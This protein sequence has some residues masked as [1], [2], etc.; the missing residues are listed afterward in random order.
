[1]ST[2]DPVRCVGL[3]FSSS[4]KSQASASKSGGR[5][6][7]MMREVLKRGELMG[8]WLMSK[9]TRSPPS[10]FI[11]V[12]S[13]RSG[14]KHCKAVAD[15]CRRGN[16]AHQDSWESFPATLS[17]RSFDKDGWVNWIGD[18]TGR[19]EDWSATW[20]SVFK[21]RKTRHAMDA[22]NVVDASATTKP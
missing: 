4:V 2:Y 11:R 5:Y 12:H 15:N 18:I 21:L 17:F 7:K 22:V 1:M 20:L 6:G 16:L 10:C 9:S 14:F 13:G 3:F 19:R 8:S